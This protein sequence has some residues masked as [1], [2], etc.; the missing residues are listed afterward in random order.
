MNDEASTRKSLRKRLAEAVFGLEARLAARWAYWA[1]K[2]LMDAQW[3]IKPNPEWFDHHLDLYYC[4]LRDRNSLWVERGAFGSLALK[5]GDL[6]ELACGDGFNSRNFYSLRSRRVVACD[7]DPTA[8][9]TARRKNSAPN[10]EY[11][12]ADIRTQMPEGR[13]ENVVWDAAIEHFTPAEIA[14][15]MADIKR[16]LTPDGILSGYSIVERAGGGK[17]IHQ[18]EYEFADMDD[19][20]RFLSPHFR[21]VKVFET[22]FPSRHNLYFW[23]SDGALPFDAGWPHMA[24]S[25]G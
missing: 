17:A 22:I 6:L 23:A 10:V 12:L 5:H 8:L 18:H 16:R 1:H 24:E 19:L 13:F 25:R 2:R 9:A 21:N 14:K 4:F 3:Y 7:F 20:K 11:I 15:I